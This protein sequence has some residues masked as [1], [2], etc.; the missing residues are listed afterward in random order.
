M[1]QGSPQ[2]VTN[3]SKNRGSWE[4]GL[5]VRKSRSTLANIST[6]GTQ[7]KRK[8]GGSAIWPS[9]EEKKEGLKISSST[10]QR[11]DE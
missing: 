1:S 6:K 5:L 10:L 3:I 8:L 9:G 4:S 2:D 11:A 7:R